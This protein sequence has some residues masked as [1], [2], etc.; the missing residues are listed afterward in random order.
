MQR[1]SGG[2]GRRDGG[3]PFDR[4]PGEFAEQRGA[5]GPPVGPGGGPFGGPFGGG[6]FGGPFGGFRSGHGGRG[7]GGRHG[8]RARR[9]DVRASLL[10]LLTERPMHGYEMITEIGE[11]TSGAWRPSPGSVYPT[12]QLLEEEGLIEA[13]ETGGKRLFTLTEAGRAA[14]EAGAPEPWQ[15]AGRGIDWEAVQEVGQALASVDHAIRQ[16]MAT[17]TEEQRTKGL[18][19]LVEARK[20]LYLILAE[21]G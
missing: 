7:R 18:A 5:Y 11:R 12:L 16:V 19:V 3:R 14:A 13:Q 15:E 6:P 9:G 8:G 20:K 21:E 4:I 10:A 2:R 17:G 1:T